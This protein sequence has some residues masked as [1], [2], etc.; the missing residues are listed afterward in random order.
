MVITIKTEKK[1]KKKKKLRRKTGRANDEIN[2]L[3]KTRRT[4]SGCEVTGY[5]SNGTW[6]IEATRAFQ[7]VLFRSV[8]SINPRVPT[9]HFDVEAA[10]MRAKLLVDVEERPELGSDGGK[11]SCFVPARRLWQKSH[12]S[13]NVLHAC[14]FPT[15][16]SDL[17]AQ[18][19]KKRVVTTR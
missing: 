14:M 18:Q 10:G 13:T 4:T 16:F 7:R 2:D 19:D 11:V 12:V 9:G 17:G 5:F 15:G 8:I 3:K 6:H 1:K